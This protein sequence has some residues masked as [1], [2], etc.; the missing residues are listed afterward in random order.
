MWTLWKSAGSQPGSSLGSWSSAPRLATLHQSQMLWEGRPGALS[1]HVP[2]IRQPLNMGNGTA[3]VKGHDPSIVPA[4]D[5]NGMP[6]AG[7]DCLQEEDGSVMVRDDLDALLMVLLSSLSVNGWLVNKVCDCYQMSLLFLGPSGATT[8]HPRTP[9]ETSCQS[10][11]TG[12][13]Y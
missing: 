5:G 7:Q 11:V 1:R 12:G 9:G 6:D 13:M 10:F 4:R 2:A 3:S 8:G